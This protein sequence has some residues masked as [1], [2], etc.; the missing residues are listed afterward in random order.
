VNG[1]CKGDCSKPLIMTRSNTSSGTTTI[2]IVLIVV[3]TFPIWVGIAGG[4]FGLIA[5]LFGAAIG[6]IAA[7]CGAIIGVFGAVISGLFG[8]WWHDSSANISLNVFLAICLV[9]AIVRLSKVRRD[10]D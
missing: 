1:F 8:G 10:K 9:L 3:F 2:L 6:I 5:G 7:V 4:L